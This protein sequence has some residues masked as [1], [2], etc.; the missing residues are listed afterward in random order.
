[1]RAKIKKLKLETQW[2]N[3]LKKFFKEVDKP[4]I[5]VNQCIK[6]YPEYK[7]EKF[8][9]GYYIT[10]GKQE[11]ILSEVEE[12]RAVYD[13]IRYPLLERGKYWNLFMIL[14]RKDYENKG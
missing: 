1:M 12:I 6:K 11:F 7:L 9:L 4:R 10:V 3:P 2:E 14:R 13:R 8:R 5:I